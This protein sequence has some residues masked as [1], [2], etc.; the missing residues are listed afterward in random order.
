[1][2][3]EGRG[4]ALSLT[5]ELDSAFFFGEDEDLVKKP[6]MDDEGAAGKDPALFPIFRL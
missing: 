1:M 5:L 2:L 6:L 4:E 3:T